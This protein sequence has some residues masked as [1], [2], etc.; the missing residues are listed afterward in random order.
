MKDGYTQD[1]FEQNTSHKQANAHKFF[2]ENVD[3]DIRTSSAGFQFSIS[4][5]K[6]V[7]DSEDTAYVAFVK[8]Y[9]QEFRE[10]II[11]TLAYYAEN[12]SAK[13]V[14][15]HTNELRRYLKQKE[16]FTLTGLLLYKQATPEHSRDE[17]IS[18]FRCF[19]RQM[20]YLGFDVPS[21]FMK[22]F[23]T[24]VLK[25]SEKGV[26]VLSQDPE[27]GPYSELEFRAIKAGLDY[28]YADGT[29]SDREY[30]L[31]QLFLATFR[32]PANLKQLKVK[33]L[34][35][36]SNVLVTKQAIFQVNIPRTKG[37][38]RK[39]R[40]Q[41][42]AFVVI[43]SIGL[44]LTKHIQSAIKL[45]ETN[46]GRKLS[47]EEIKELPMFF[48]DRM[49]EELEELP[50]SKV[51]DYLKSEI[52][53]L[54]TRELTTELKK[55]IDKLNIISER[56]GEPLRTTAYR[57]RYSGGT[58]AAEAGAGLITIA[59]L[60]DHGD[61]NH[62]GVYIANSP[63]IG[64]Q[65]SKI[66]N[67]PLARYASAFLGKVV[68]GEDEAFEQNPGATRIPCREKQCD[69]GSC[70][71]SSFCTDY[72]PVACYL[73]PK[74]LPWRDAPHHEVLHWLLDE[75]ERLSNT[76]NDP[77]VVSINDSAIL[78]VA[79]VMKLCEQ[80]KSND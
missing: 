45:A 61:N 79:Q 9:A 14:V 4:D 62:A 67:N 72:A 60:L 51:M 26:P 25:G 80:E 24:W 46:M 69:V 58:R 71:S 1:V 66:M 40:S 10:G 74:F 8:Q 28:K 70:G 56:T 59:E 22:E 77:K 47:V 53:H 76:L 32:R 48:N 3:S 34:L 18:R 13:Y 5:E 6:W 17:C 12:R 49:F 38:G 27:E 20:L 15:T 63:E 36:S 2:G 29:I 37:K 7:L 75:R 30:S 11:T 35:A 16:S 73:C 21:S 39:F 57:F 65:I 68:E 31:A 78:A 33:D 41:F 55:I 44:V 43:E 64:Q 23:N 52:P 50:A 54:S 42:K 19:L